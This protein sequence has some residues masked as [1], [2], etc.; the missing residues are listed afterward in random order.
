MIKKLFRLVHIFILINFLE[1][2]IYSQQ[3][4]PFTIERHDFIRYDKNQFMF[5]G[6]S[7]KFI[8]LYKQ[9]DKLILEGSGQVHVVHMGGSHIQAGSLSGHMSERLQTFFPGLK[10]SRGFIFPYRIAR[11]NNPHNYLVRGTGDWQTCRSVQRNKLCTLGLSGI[12]ITTNNP[13]STVGIKLIEDVYMPYDFNIVKIFHGTKETS[14]EAFIKSDTLLIAADT[15]F[16][17]LGYS[18]YTLDNYTDELDFVIQRTDSLQN[19]FT[20]HGISLE[21]NDPGIIY[22]GI[23]V[24]GASIPCY[25]RCDKLD[26]HLKALHPDWIILTLGTN[27]AY[28]T[29]FD[30]TVY[31]NDYEMLLNRLEKAVPDAAILMTVPNDS[32]YR[33]RYVN[34]NTEEVRKVIIK[35]AKKHKC[36]VWDFYSV[37]GGLNSI[38]LWYKAGLTSTDKLHFNRRGYFLQA[39]LL[40]NAFL[41]SYDNYLELK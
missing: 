11:T 8:N 23:G 24:N 7:S 38:S 10:G 2:N 1:V 19:H 6:D 16:M 21:S 34:H 39:D 28:T 4:N 27:D 15:T 37:M 41:K 35:L 20:L 18:L 22:H 9:I 26:E 3:D 40:F 32:Y 14:F 25:L 33:R 36:G 17:D 12:S 29:N 30:T 5:F 13:G 31:E